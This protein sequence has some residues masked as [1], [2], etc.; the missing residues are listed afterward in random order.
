MVA[1]DLAMVETGVRFPLPAPILFCMSK[2]TTSVLNYLR[3]IFNILIILTYVVGLIPLA[4]WAVFYI[5][6]PLLIANLIFAIQKKETGST[7]NIAINLLLSLITLIPLIGS[8]TAIGGIVLSVLDI[9]KILPEVKNDDKSIIDLGKKNT[10][11][12][13]VEVTPEK[14]ETDED[15]DTSETKSKTKVEK[16]VKKKTI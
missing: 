1:H 9:L 15:F 16:V 3:L 13:T 12:Q 2:K 7:R 6:I 8:L 5:T 4:F 10:T 11:N 14:V